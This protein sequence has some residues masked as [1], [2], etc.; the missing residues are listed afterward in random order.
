M[1]QTEIII[2]L[3]NLDNMNKGKWYYLK[4]VILYLKQNN[5]LASREKDVSNDL[6]RLCLFNMVEI[7]INGL[8]NPKREYR[9]K[10]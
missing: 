10:Q 8:T 2:G 4:E 7:R 9:I 6:Y 1:G 3:K 5:L